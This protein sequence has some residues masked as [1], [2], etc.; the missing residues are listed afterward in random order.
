[1]NVAAYWGPL[2]EMTFSGN[3]KTLQICS[4]NSLATPREVTSDVEEW[5]ESF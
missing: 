2:S 4:R 3:L 1:M 5:L